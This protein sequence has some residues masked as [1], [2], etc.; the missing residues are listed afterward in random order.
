VAQAGEVLDATREA[1]RALEALPPAFADVRDDVRRQLH[2]LVGPGFITATGDRRMADVL[3][4]VR[5]AVR[6]L[7]RL[8]AAPAVDRDRMRGVH[9][10]EDAYRRRLESWPRGRALPETLREVPWLLQELRVSHFAQG[11]G[12]RGQVSSKRI[13][14]V[15]DDA[16]AAAA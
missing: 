11:L 8:P 16:S 2:E 14:R 4:Y 15:L 1:D 5:A 13:R 12:T 9:E 6:R 10:L 7:E 3:R